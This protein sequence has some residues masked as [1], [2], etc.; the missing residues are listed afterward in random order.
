MP[1][2][3]DRAQRRRDVTTAAIKLLADRGPGALTFRELARAMGGSIT[4]VT[5]YYPN[6]AS[7]LEGITK[8]L[9]DDFDTDLAEQ[10]A[11]LRPSAKLRA[12]LEWMLPLDEAG[13]DEELARILLL[14]ARDPELPLQQ[15]F[16][17]IEAKMRS[18]LRDHL[19]ALIPPN[20]VEPTVEALRVLVNGVVLSVVEHPSE[21]T[22]PRQIAVL[23][24]LLVALGLGDDSSAG[25]VRPP[26]QLV[27]PSPGKI[28]TMA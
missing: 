23:D 10:Q 20:D 4:L 19:A 13:R 27:T 11:G 7:L 14:G 3:V 9:I 2:H 28:S 12:L 24:R 5:H 6:R 1:R 16:D 15:F 25:Q 8:Q 21:W 22:R 26:V 18:L 17:A